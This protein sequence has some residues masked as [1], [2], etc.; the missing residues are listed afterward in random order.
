M[1]C[2]TLTAEDR[3]CKRCLKRL[4]TEQENEKIMEQYPEMFQGG[5]Q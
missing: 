2:E 3:L 1:P 4:K 5:A